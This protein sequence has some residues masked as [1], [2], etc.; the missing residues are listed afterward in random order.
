MGVQ[1]IIVGVLFVSSLL[2][3]GQKFY[4]SIRSKDCGTA[5]SGCSSVDLSKIDLS[6]FEKTSSRTISQ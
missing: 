3:I 5:C 1:E 2:Y 4:K 6:K